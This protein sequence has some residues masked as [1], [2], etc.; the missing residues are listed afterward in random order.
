MVEKELVP[1]E[2]IFC[3]LFLSI[4]V[5]FYKSTKVDWSLDHP[6]VLESMI[7]R[8]FLDGKTFSFSFVFSSW[9]QSLHHH[10]MDLLNKGNQDCTYVLLEHP[11]RSVHWH[12]QD[13]LDILLKKS[14][15]VGDFLLVPWLL[16][17]PWSIGIWRLSWSLKGHLNLTIWSSFKNGFRGLDW[18][19]I[20]VKLLIIGKPFKW[21]EFKQFLLL[22]LFRNLDDCWDC[23]CVCK[24]HQCICGCL[25]SGKV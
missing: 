9:F 13:I 23:I 8:E 24:D 7:C 3:L 19:W 10:H 15:R 21:H 5:P 25:C 2:L 12:C 11:I 20:L 6:V 1:V 17:E 14:H 16:R 18:L 4:W 22:N